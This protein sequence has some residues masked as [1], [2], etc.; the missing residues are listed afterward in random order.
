MDVLTPNQRKLNMSR[1]RG[2]NT[3]PELI[4]RRGLHATGL[5]FR[6]HVRNLPGRPDLVFP[7]FRAVIFLH[8]C[9][10]HGHNCSL[11]QIPATRTDFWLSKIATNQRRDSRV[12]QALASLGWRT[13][14]VWE[15]AIKG[16]NR[17]PFNDVVERCV[18]FVKGARRQS[19]IAEMARRRNRQAAQLSR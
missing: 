1:I 9:F 6:L 8:G 12:N 7:R 17:R 4:L 19:Y 3:K 15:C 13:M 16:P 14:I 10:W 11:F 2:K 18:E 5:R